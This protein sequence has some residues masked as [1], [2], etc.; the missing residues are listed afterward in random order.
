MP[1]TL[2]RATVTLPPDTAAALDRLAARL[3]R[4]RADALR[5]AL[6]RGLAAFGELPPDPVPVPAADV[7]RLLRDLQAAGWTLAAL[8]ERVGVT[9]ATLSRWATGARR[10]GRGSGAAVAE[11]RQIAIEGRTE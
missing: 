7:A 9:H 11:L 1:S 2:P 10:P 3:D 6:R 5:A 4:P 8:A